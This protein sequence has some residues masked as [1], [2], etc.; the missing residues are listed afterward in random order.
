MRHSWENRFTAYVENGMHV[1]CSLFKDG[2]YSFYS[3]DEKLQ[4]SDTALIRVLS[5]GGNST[6]V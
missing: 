5:P 4:L 1:N 2:K 3:P 6:R